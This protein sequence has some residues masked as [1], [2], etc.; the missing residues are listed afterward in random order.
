MRIAFGPF[1]A[2]EPAIRHNLDRRHTP[3]FDDLAEIRPEDF[4]AVVPLPTA[5][6][7]VLA[8]HPALRGRKFFHP[9]PDVAA[10]CHDKRAL[11]RFL[12]DQGFGDLVPPLRA[13]GPPYPYVWKRRIGGWGQQ[14]RLVDGLDAER[15]LDLTDP[16][17]FA[18]AVTSGTTEYATHILRTGGQVRYASTFVYEM[19]GAAVILGER[20]G[21]RTIRFQRGSAHLALFAD[22]L[23]RLDYEGTACFDYKLADG[24]P[25]L[26]EINP[27]FGA[28][29][30]FDINAYVEAYVA[31]LG[32]GSAR[33]PASISPQSGQS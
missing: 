7:K 18:Q 19:A 5:D 2:W 29:L 27:R 1:P 25:R 26:F 17:W 9:A 21:P 31:A 28:S 24:A 8:R 12:I 33:G 3:S 22:I 14:C 6:Y 13:P 23:A 20:N 16:D 10:L 15:G 11:N 4:D 30:A 32:I